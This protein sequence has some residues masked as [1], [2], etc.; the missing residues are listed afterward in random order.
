VSDHTRLVLVFFFFKKSRVQ[1]PS[2]ITLF[3]HHFSS[4]LFASPSSP[5]SRSSR[6]TPPKRPR[7]LSETR[8]LHEL[9]GPRL[10][11]LQKPNFSSQSQAPPRNYPK[12]RRPHRLFP[13]D[14]QWRRPQQIFRGPSL[15]EPPKVL[16]SGR[17][18]RR[19]GLFSPTRLLY[20]VDVVAC[21]L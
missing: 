15:V 4:F 3:T 12:R 17:R 9:Q 18:I 14:L 1:N 16:S 5:S 20:L 6:G 7:H 11:E 2:R 10:L 13:S 19:P 21:G 8:I